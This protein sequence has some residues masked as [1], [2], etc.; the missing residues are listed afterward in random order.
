MKLT[1][2]CYAVLTLYLTLLFACSKE[3]V[4]TEPSAGELVFNKNCKVCHAQG[5]NGAPI[6]GN[7][8]MWQPRLSKGEQA[9][10]QSAL[11]G[12]GLMPARGGK[13][14]KNGSQLLPDEDIKL[15]VAFMLSKVE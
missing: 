8:A 14:G 7:Q 12:F 11:N 13:D 1:F 5:I 9:L 2:F 4:D 15:A 10:V 6:I 3:Q